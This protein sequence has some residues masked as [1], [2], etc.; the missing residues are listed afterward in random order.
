VD[1]EMK[2]DQ[3]NLFSYLDSSPIRFDGE[4]YQPERDDERL[5]GQI[6]R[7]FNLMRD[8]N[9]RTLDEIASITGDPQAS[10]SAQ[11]RHL[12]KKKFG[13]HTVDKRHRG[14][15]KNGLYEYQL[16]VNY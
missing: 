3:P 16:K 10:I 11:L 7:V 12:R 13:N 2:Q 9:W 4:C 8:G 5:T 14:E 6:L 1:K 15:A